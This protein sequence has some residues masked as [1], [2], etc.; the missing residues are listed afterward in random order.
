MLGKL[1]AT[2]TLSLLTVLATPALAHHRYDHPG[3][4]D[5]HDPRGH[6]DRHDDDRDWDD[7]DWDDDDDRD[8]ERRRGHRHHPDVA[9]A[10]EPAA[11]LLVGVGLAGAVLLRRKLSQP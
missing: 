11:L 6:H 4:R 8:H 7:D 2:L 1:L 5:H 9:Q 3:G 10:P